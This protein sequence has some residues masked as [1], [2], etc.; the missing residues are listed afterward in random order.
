MAEKNSK[1]RA[2]LTKVGYSDRAC[3]DGLQI[4]DNKGDIFWGGSLQLIGRELVVYIC[5]A[6]ASE[7]KLGSGVR[8]GGRHRRLKDNVDVQ[9][10]HAM[11]W[12]G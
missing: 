6:Y 1:M 8:I 7:G 10:A 5:R 11:I 2:W 9:K 12:G 3:V 4:E